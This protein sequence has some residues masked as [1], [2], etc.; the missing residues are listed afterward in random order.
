M[1]IKTKLYEF[2][3]KDETD[4]TYGEKRDLQKVFLKKTN[5][6]DFSGKSLSLTGDSIVVFQDELLKK[7][8]HKIV[9]LST[10]EIIETDCFEYLMNL[11][12]SDPDQVYEKV[13]SLFFAIFTKKK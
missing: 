12:T 7:L 9:V 5:I 2:H 3:L 4:L 13:N 8:L 6:N 1:L 10:G 11:K